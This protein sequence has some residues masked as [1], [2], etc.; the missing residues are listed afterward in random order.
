MRDFA[1]VRPGVRAIGIGA[2]MGAVLSGWNLIGMYT[3]IPVATWDLWRQVLFVLAFAGTSAVSVHSARARFG[4][5]LTCT[6]AVLTAVGC[7]ATVVSAYA[8]S[9]AFGTARIKQVPEFIRDYTHHGYASPATYFADHY[10]PLLQL[11]VFAWGIGAACLAGV[12][13]AIG[14][15]VGRNSSMST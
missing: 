14:L 8:L 2:G 1:F 3:A 10:W 4:W 15:A 12:G 5:A 7:A 11:Q 9:T 13:A 6:S